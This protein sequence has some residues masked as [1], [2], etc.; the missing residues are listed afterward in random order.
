MVRVSGYFEDRNESLLRDWMR[1]VRKGRDKDDTKPLV[2]SHSPLR[3]FPRLLRSGVEN[4]SQRSSG[5][6]AMAMPLRSPAC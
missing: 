6:A 1:V 2:L 3:G 4:T 5:G